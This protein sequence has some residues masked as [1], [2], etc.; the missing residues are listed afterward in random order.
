MILA[1]YKFTD[2]ENIPAM[3]TLGDNSTPVWNQQ[4]W[5]EGENALYIRRNGCGHCCTAMV[6]NLRGINITPYE[7][8]MHCRFLWGLPDEN[9]NPPQDHFLSVGGIVK[10]LKSFG[11]KAECFGV[12]KDKATACTEHIVS[13]LKDGK[14]VII[15]S[16]PMAEFP[17]NPFS[18]GDHYVLAAGIS[19]NDKILI[20]NSSGKAAPSGIQLVDV[21]TVEKA[22]YPDSTADDAMTW[23]IV[24]KLPEGCGYVIID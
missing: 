5:T 6:L 17:D 16:H 21:G 13:A 3:V 1:S 23:G 12:P 2:N 14:L 24:E 4:S 18:T 22:L 15:E 8:Y 7:E 19:E 20:A 10:V 11:L 9:A